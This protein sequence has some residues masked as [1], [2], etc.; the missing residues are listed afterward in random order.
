LVEGSTP[1]LLTSVED[2][3]DAMR[4][5]EAAY[6]SSEEGNAVAALER[7]TSAQFG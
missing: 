1:N 5:V 6:Q 2:S 3:I 4:T 7:A